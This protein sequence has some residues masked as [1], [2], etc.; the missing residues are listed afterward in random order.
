MFVTDTNSKHGNLILEFLKVAPSY[1]RDHLLSLLPS[2]LVL[3]WKLR[4]EF[5]SERQ[6]KNLKM[7]NM[8]FVPDLALL[9]SWKMLW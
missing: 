2:L 6:K 5:M 1:P 9:R 3:I 8:N 4:N 7:N